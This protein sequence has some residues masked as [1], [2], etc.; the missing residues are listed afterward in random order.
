M[1]SAGSAELFLPLLQLRRWSV[2]LVSST[3]LSSLNP[4][5]LTPPGITGTQL[6]ARGTLPSLLQKQC[7]WGENEVFVY[8]LK[9]AKNH[10]QSAGSQ[11]ENGYLQ[12]I[13]HFKSL[14]HDRRCCLLRK[15]VYK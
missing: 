9:M 1:L 4:D 15:A 10:L 5:T 14:G 7:K 12:L 3:E 13:N 6:Q 8:V 2:C 11:T